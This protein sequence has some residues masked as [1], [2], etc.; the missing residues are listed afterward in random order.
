MVSMQLEDRIEELNWIDRKLQEV[1]DSG[2][3]SQDCLRV[4]ENPGACEFRSAWTYK[5]FWID[6]IPPLLLFFSHPFSFS[7]SLS[8]FPPF[9]PHPSSWC[10][11]KVDWKK[12]FSKKVSIL[13]RQVLQRWAEFLLLSSPPLFLPSLSLF[14]LLSSFS[15]L[16]LT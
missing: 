9:S 1:S 2:I 13:N 6:S 11:Q 10:N 16:F 5:W 12:H 7:R 4:F 3:Q 15:L 8:L 14:P